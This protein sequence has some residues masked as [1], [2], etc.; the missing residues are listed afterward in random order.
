[1]IKKIKLLYTFL[2]KKTTFH[3]QKELN[4]SEADINGTIFFSSH[5]KRKMMAIST[6]LRKSSQPTY[7]QLLMLF[8]HQLLFSAKEG[9]SEEFNNKLDE[10]I[11]MLLEWK[12]KQD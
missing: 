1:M 12:S 3:F 5:D 2:F 10:I 7:S 9:S 11:V 6:Q 8:T 4:D